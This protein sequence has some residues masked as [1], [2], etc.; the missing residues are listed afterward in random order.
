MVLNCFY[1][2]K[3]FNLTKQFSGLNPETNFVFMFAEADETR[4]VIQEDDSITMY[5]ITM[6]E[7]EDVPNTGI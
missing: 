7:E 4:F 5:Q 3:F 2:R 1:H 6:P